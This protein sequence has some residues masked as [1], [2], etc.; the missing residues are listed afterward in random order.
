MLIFSER[1]FKHF[2]IQIIVMNQAMMF[3]FWTLGRYLWYQNCSKGQNRRRLL[4]I[5]ARKWEYFFNSM[6]MTKL[7]LLLCYP[8]ENFFKVVI[9]CTL[10]SGYLGSSWKCDVGTHM[11]VI[12]NSIIPYR[13][14]CSEI[15]VNFLFPAM[16]DFTSCIINHYNCNV[17]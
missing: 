5:S 4:T 6:L 12:Y 7:C 15:E 14:K 8:K 17:G 13:A 9:R 1:S 16:E 11:M 10:C 3:S 2:F